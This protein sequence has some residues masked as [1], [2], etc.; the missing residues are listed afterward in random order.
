MFTV[1]EGALAAQKMVV[2][3]MIILHETWTWEGFEIFLVWVII[4]IQKP[5]I[6]KA[7]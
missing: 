1:N 6:S 7:R 2:I 5:D 4:V 3:I